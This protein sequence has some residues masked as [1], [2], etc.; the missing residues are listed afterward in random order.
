MSHLPPRGIRFYTSNGTN[1]NY[2][3]VLMERPCFTPRQTRFSG[4]AKCGMED[5]L[6]AGLLVGFVVD[7]KSLYKY[8]K[9]S[10][11]LVE[12]SDIDIRCPLKMD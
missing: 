11:K 7:S 2:V 9:F 4:F 5:A 12:V 3:G 10:E 6:S 8:L 1:T